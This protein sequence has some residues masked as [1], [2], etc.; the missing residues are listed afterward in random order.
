MGQR[1]AAVTPLRPAG[2]VMLRERRVDVVTRGEHLETGDP[3]VVVKV[4]GNR[5]IVERDKEPS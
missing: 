2:I 3:V 1:G 4:E 5:V